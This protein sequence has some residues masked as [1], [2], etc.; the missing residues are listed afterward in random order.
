MCGRYTITLEP[1]DFEV[2]L[3]IS[4]FPPDFAPRYNVAPTQQVVAVRDSEAKKAEWLKW[5]LIPYW[6]KDPSIGAR[7]INARSETLRE[8]PSFRQAFERRRCLILADGFYEW[9][10]HEGR[11]STPFYIQLKEGKPFAFAGLWE[12]WQSAEEEIISCTIITCAANEMI[13]PVHDRM[14]VILDKTTAWN[15]LN[16]ASPEELSGYLVPYPSEDM[17][18]VQIGTAINN[19]HV[20]SPDLIIPV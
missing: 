19:S 2:E 18:M 16:P 7:M 6:A 14:P 17:Q 11:P 8:K 9:Q 10:K 3:G 1:A 5:G 15:W 13:K 4:D 20:E 12:K